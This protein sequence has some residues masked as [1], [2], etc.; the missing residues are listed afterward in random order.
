MKAQIYAHSAFAGLNR[1]LTGSSIPALIA[2]YGVSTVSAIVVYVM[3]SSSGLTATLS[4]ST[5]SIMLAVAFAAQLAFAPYLPGLKKV[6]HPAIEI[7]GHGILEAHGTLRGPLGKLADAMGL[8]VFGDSL[9]TRKAAEYMKIYALLLSLDAI[10][11]F[12]FWFVLFESVFATSTVVGDLL[13]GAAA[14]LI[15]VA[16]ALFELT[17]LTVDRSASRPSRAFHS[18]FRTAVACSLAFVIAPVLESFI[19]RPAIDTWLRMERAQEQ[20]AI[21][22]RYRQ[23]TT[24]PEHVERWRIRAFE[25]ATRASFATTE[26]PRDLLSDLRVLKQMRTSG[27]PL[28]PQLTSNDVA[29][30]QTASGDVLF[31]TAATVNRNDVVFLHN[32]VLLLVL[33]TQLTPAILRLFM[34]YELQ[35]YYNSTI[36]A[37]AGLDP[38]LSAIRPRSKVGVQVTASNRPGESDGVSAAVVS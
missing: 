35:I 24:T 2:T 15:T 10:W 25:L 29:A 8:T 16:V 19:L 12:A 30:L 22:L 6:L 23:L 34:P 14:T 31:R 20:F 18:L 28:S 32:A 4:T 11:H 17:A 27:V 3:M 26:A 33:L 1:F 7:D 21:E 36:Q 37:D 38:I 5:L 13:S 9:L